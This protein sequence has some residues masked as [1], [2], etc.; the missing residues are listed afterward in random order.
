MSLFGL[1]RRSR[2]SRSG[3][4]PEPAAGGN[5]TRP[6]TTREAP[7]A[8]VGPVAP[9]PPG[10]DEVRRI[11]FDAV[12]SGDESRLEALCREHKAFILEHAAGW[13]DVP[14]SFRASPEAYEWYGNGLR[15]IARFC[16]D[17]LGRNDLL[18]APDAAPETGT[19]AN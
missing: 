3:A 8:P 6:T 12:A 14:A 13:L 4:E 19:R 11:L 9:A 16:A 5:G 10:P 1:F 7:L 2:T 18:P 17:K 15:A